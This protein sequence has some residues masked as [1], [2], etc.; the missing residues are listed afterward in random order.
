MRL[1]ILS[2]LHLSRNGLPLPSVEADVVI[3]AGDISRPKEA[4]EWASG[5]SKP[6]LYVAGNHEFYGGG[7]KETIAQL[8]HYAAGKPIY[9][10][11]NEELVLH[12]IRFIGCTLWTDFNLAGPGELR[13]QAIAQALEFTYDFRRIKSDAV[14]GTPFSPLEMEALFNQHRAWLQ[15]RLATPFDGP[16]VVITHHAPSTQS[17]HPRF[18][19]SLINT[20]FVS[21]SEYLMN[22]DRATLWIHGH[23]HDSFDYQVRGTRVVC[24]PRGYA[25]DGINENPFFN[26]DL[27]INI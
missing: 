27:V 2:D 18:E 12:G 1:N 6:V 19:N 4:M 21:D 7:I 17:I 9:V 13:E 24:N 25:R 22:A 16:T 5:F 26:P 23:T 14:P 15:Q 10:L 11:D 3:L 20:C 8:K